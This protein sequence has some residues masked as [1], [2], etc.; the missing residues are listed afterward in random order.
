MD[1]AKPGPTPS[2]LA[3]HEEP[4][5][6]SRDM[7]MHIRQQRQAKPALDNGSSVGQWNQCHVCH[8]AAR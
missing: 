2:L 3:Q 4:R 1:N 6:W 8:E 7:A 5:C